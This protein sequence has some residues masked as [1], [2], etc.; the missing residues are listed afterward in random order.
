MLILVLI[1]IV[2][3][4]VILTLVIIR[5]SST[6]TQWINCYPDAESKFS[7]Y[8]KEACL[9]RNCLFDETASINDIQYYLN[10]VYGYI[11]QQEEPTESGIRI[12]LRRNQTV[13]SMFPEPIDNVVLDVQYYTNDILRFKFYD[14]D[15]QRYEVRSIWIDASRN[16]FLS[17]YQ[18]YWLVRPVAPCHHNMNSSIHR[19][20]YLTIC[21]HS[22][23]NVVQLKL[24]YL[25]HRL[26]VL[27]SIIN[28]FK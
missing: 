18:F 6:V 14:D 28:F 20:F 10:P 23:S 16:Q 1:I 2:V 3:V 15:N 22:S 4:L 8:S 21:F 5:R 11:F 7:N 9:K 24:F 17:R 27:Y 26:V 19:M 12:K 25:T 13:N